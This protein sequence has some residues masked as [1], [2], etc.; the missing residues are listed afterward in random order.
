MH[1]TIRKLLLSILLSFTIPCPT[2]CSTYPFAVK[3]HTAF[4]ERYTYFKSSSRS[5]VVE[6]EKGRYPQGSLVIVKKCGRSNTIPLSRPTTLHALRVIKNL[7]A[8]Q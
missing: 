4:G 5:L 7:L 3:Y 2:S 1:H 6:V 8:K